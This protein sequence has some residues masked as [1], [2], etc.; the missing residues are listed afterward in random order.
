MKLF[1]CEIYDEINYIDLSQ[2]MNILRADKVY[3]RT[4]AQLTSLYIETILV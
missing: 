4:T 1:K 3:V 2:Y